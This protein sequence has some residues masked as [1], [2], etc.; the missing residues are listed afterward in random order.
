MKRQCRTALGFAVAALIA[1]FI[2]PAE[3]AAQ[4]PS[5]SEPLAKEL[6][7]LL[8][9]GGLTYVAAKSDEADFYVAAL[10]IP[11]VQLLVVRAKYSVPVLL[12]ERLAKKEYQDAYIDLN[13]ASVPES[14]IFVEDLKS[15]GLHAT[16][17][18]DQPFDIYEE[19]T[20]RTIFDGDWKKQKLTE[21]AYMG[22]FGAA[23]DKYARMLAAL[24]AQLK[25]G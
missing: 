23:D 14:K 4:G 21:D 2:V 22:K 18:G 24:I 20:V 5:K 15:D 6:V 25:K 12:N 3:L 7:Q 1:S 8:E 11:G 10:H 17:E 19:G 9:K 16:R 13:S